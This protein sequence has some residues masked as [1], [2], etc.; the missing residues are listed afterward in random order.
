MNLVHVRIQLAGLLD[1][2]DWLK[3]TF[4]SHAAPEEAVQHISIHPGDGGAL[5]VGFWISA[6]SALASE[7][8]AYAVTQRTLHAETALSQARVTSYSSTLVPAV[9]N[10]M[11]REPQEPGRN[12]LWTNAEAPEN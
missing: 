6:P 12:M 3:R 11:L 7:Q 10:Q 8:V 2:Y 4:R 5:T 9:F 1:Q